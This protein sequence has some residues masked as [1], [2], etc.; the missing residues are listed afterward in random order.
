MR[1][2]IYGYTNDEWLAL[3]ADERRVANG[4]MAPVGECG[5]CDR[6]RANNDSAMPSHT[7]SPRCQSNKY[8]H[9]TCDT[10]Y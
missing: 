9:C 1:K 8:P 6:A 3:S 4:Y 7:A 2:N 10:C 5:Y